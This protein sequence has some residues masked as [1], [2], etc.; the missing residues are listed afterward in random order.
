[1]QHGG[2]HLDFLWL[3][4]SGDAAQQEDAQ[5]WPADDSENLRIYL[6]HCHGLT[7]AVSLSVTK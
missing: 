4:S 2:C 7:A 3:L 1:M 5:N 6:G